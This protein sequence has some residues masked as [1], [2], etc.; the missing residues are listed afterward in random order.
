MIY[1]PC[2]ISNDDW[3]K[4]LIHET[5]N[6]CPVNTRPFCITF[7]QRRPNVFDVVYQHCINV[8]QMFCVYWVISLGNND[9]LTWFNAM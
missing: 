2:S 1:H 9:G 7:I 4:C 5:C 6:A 8:I 3:R